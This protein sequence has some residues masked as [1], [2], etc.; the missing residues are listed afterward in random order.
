MEDRKKYDVKKEMNSFYNESLEVLGE[1]F[2]Q[3][4]AELI[5]NTGPR[6]D[7]Y[8]TP[9]KVFVLAELPGLDSQNQIGIVLSGQTLIIEGEIPRLYP[10][11]ENRITQNER[12]FGKFRRSLQMPKP[13]TIDGNQAKY[14]KGLLIIELQVDEKL[15]QTTVPINYTETN[16]N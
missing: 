11:T 9:T 16:Q 5:P 4:I 3:D 8:Y 2:W 10:V 12:F 13:V 15:Q 6:I 1:Q 14:S 7:I